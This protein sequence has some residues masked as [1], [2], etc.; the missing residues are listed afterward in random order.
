MI[1]KNLN[2]YLS[3]YSGN[4]VLQRLQAQVKALK[5]NPT[6]TMREFENNMSSNLL[7]LEEL[8]QKG[9]VKAKSLDHPSPIIKIHNY[10]L[11]KRC[12]FLR[13]FSITTFN[14]Y[15]RVSDRIQHI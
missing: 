6:Q 9:I 13:K 2:T 8:I 11:F 1:E 3:T 7:A 5:N 14:Y 10:P 15:S 4:E 12:E